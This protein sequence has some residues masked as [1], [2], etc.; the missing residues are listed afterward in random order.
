V[1]ILT[2]LASWR[3]RKAQPDFAAAVPDPW[4]GRIGL[5]RGSAAG[6]DAVALV[7]S[8][9]F[10]RKWG[11]WPCCWVLD[12]FVFRKLQPENCSGQQAT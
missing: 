3:L 1:T 6:D 8:D 11:R 5:R 12:V 4:D 9:P 2:V 10:A 7:A